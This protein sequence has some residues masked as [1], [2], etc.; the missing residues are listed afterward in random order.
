MSRVIFPKCYIITSLEPT[1]C[2]QSQVKTAWVHPTGLHLSL[3]TLQICNIACQDWCYP[4]LMEPIIHPRAKLA[5]WLNTIVSDH[6]CWS[7]ASFNLS[8]SAVQPPV[9]NTVFPCSEW[10]LRIIFEKNVW[11]QQYLNLY[12]HKVMHCI[13]F[14]WLADWLIAWVKPEMQNE[15]LRA[16]FLDGLSFNWGE[17]ILLPMSAT[18][19]HHYYSNLI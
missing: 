3:C 4:L 18:R 6:L 8:L 13:A 10:Q 12:L 19:C 14:T 1:K 11:C 2:A 16:F 5:F 7:S 17:N 9:I 15:M